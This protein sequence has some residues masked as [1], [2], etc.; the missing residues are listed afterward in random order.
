MFS[1]VEIRL[2][3][4]ST[5]LRKGVAASAVAAPRSQRGLLGAG[6]GVGVRCAGS[7]TDPQKVEPA[8]RSES[9]TGSFSP[10][11]AERAGRPAPIPLTYGDD[12]SS[13]SIRAFGVDRIDASQ[14][15]S[16]SVPSSTSGV[17]FNPCALA[18]AGERKRNHGEGQNNGKGHLNTPPLSH[19]CRR[20]EAQAREGGLPISVVQVFGQIAVTNDNWSLQNAK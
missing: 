13:L 9:A 18:A 12:R 6:V 14:P 7:G 8:S 5:P 1:G 15:A 20:R 2:T 10:I 17:P 3:G 16:T 11:H 19:D 4:G